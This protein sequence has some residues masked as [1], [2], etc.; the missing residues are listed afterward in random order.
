MSTRSR[1]LLVNNPS[2]GRRRQSRVD[3]VIAELQSR[4]CDVVQT[5]HETSEILYDRAKLAAF[6]A[7]IGA[8]G[9][10]TVRRLLQTEAG[11]VVPLGLIP[12]GTGNV[13]AHEI[14]LKSRATVVADVLIAGPEHGV[15]MGLGDETP[16]LLMVGLGFDGAVVH[17]LHPGVKSWI[18]KAAY[19]P[20]VL[21]ALCRRPQIFM[22]Q[23]DGTSYA[24]SWAVIA[25]ARHYGGSFTIA[26]QAGLTKRSFEVVLFGAQS[27][28]VRLRQVAALAMGTIEHAP[29]AK[30]VTGER[31]AFD[32][33]GQS[34]LAQADG[35]PLTTP[36]GQI[37][38]ARPVRLIVPRRYMR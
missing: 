2:A 5:P 38:C 22:L 12:N 7:V 20:A 32:A 18:G 9:D 11:Q 28:I 15:Q 14:G 26:P 29:H 35:D 36:P 34:I 3:A 10:G 17:Q 24:A 13:L 30:T 33:L 6:D 23:I 1:F 21:R 4:G 8:G 19:I 27:R 25:N 37:S 31:I 16:F